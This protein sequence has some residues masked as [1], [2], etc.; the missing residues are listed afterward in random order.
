MTFPEHL[1]ELRTAHNLMQKDLAKELDIS[2]H[3]YQRYEYGEREP[4][5]SVLIKMARFYGISM[6][7]LVRFEP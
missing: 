3:T 4:Q 1:L 6:D 2:L 7:E 5:L